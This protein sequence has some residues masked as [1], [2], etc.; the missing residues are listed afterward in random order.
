ME[1]YTDYPAFQ[2][3]TGNYVHQGDNNIMSRDDKGVYEDQ[4]AVCIE[5]EY[6]PDCVHMPKFAELNPMV[7]P[8]KPLVKTIKY[9][10]F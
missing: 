10:F 7:T 6:Y 1:V 5:P 2:M 8:T 4:C 3:Y 9:K